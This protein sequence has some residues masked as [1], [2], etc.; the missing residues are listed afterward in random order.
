LRIGRYFRRHVALTNEHGSWVFLLSPLIVGLVAGGR[1]SV[2]SF[3]IIFTS[4]AGFLIRQP[5]TILVKIY[6]GR[7]TRRD[8]PAALFWI[9]VY[10]L[11]GT[12][13]MY[14]LVMR[15]FGYILILIVPAIPVFIWHLYLVSKRAERRQIGVGIVASGV[16]ALSAPA[17]YWIGKGEPTIMGWVLWLLMWLQSAASILYAHLRL[18]QR[19]LDKI[20]N[21][22]KRLSMSR[23]A[24]LYTTFNLIG[25]LV[26]SIT[27]FL[28]Q[29]LYLP[30][31]LQWLETMWKGII[32]PP[33]DVKPTHIGIRQLIIS[34]LFTILFI[35]AWQL[36]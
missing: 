2:D 11:I 7:R 19:E 4:L 14:A 12:V 28:P 8:L 5:I 33:V 22:S 34:S 30:Y 21:I 25:V 6:S 27:G 31:G 23:R 1:W 3:Y 29:W 9:V 15:G 17:G 24:L 36:N 32:K 13:S 26:S 16:L 35:I 20:P 18:K 10:G